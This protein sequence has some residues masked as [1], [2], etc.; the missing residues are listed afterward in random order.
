MVIMERT[1]GDIA[2]VAIEG[3]LDA[4]TSTVL[5]AKFLQM[6]DQGSLKFIFDLSKLDYVSSAGLRILLVAAK[7]MK[8]LKGKLALIQLTDNVREVFDMSGFSA[9]F[10]IYENEADAARALA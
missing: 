3:R 4:N 8:A 10:S 1:V 2:V 6:V 5:E 9:I 7:K